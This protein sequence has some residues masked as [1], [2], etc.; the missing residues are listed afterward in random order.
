V[1]T[2]LTEA[3]QATK[4]EKIYI[5]GPV[6]WKI[7][8]KEDLAQ[9]I[10][11]SPAVAGN[12]QIQVTATATVPPS[13]YG[14]TA[15]AFGNISTGTFGIDYTPKERPLFGWGGKT[16]FFASGGMSTQGTYVVGGVQQPIVRTGPVSVGA[17]VG[18]GMLGNGGILAGGIVGSW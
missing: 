7:Y 15:L 6:R 18:G 1:P 12:P 4:V 5:K 3:P 16:N 10:P 11:L 8:K 14:G 9:K 13:P 2:V 17:V